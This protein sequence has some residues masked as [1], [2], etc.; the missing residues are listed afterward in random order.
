MPKL[1]RGV[2]TVV[3]ADVA[4]QDTVTGPRALQELAERAASWSPNFDYP[5]SDTLQELA[6]NMTF[7]RPVWQFE[8]AAKPLRMTTVETRIGGN[9]EKVRV[10]YLLYRLW[11]SPWEL[12]TGISH[13]HHS[14]CLLAIIPS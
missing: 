8:F 1:A 7:R 6:K 11:L 3:P 14:F 13:L 4:E 10:W 5:K 9:T 2:L 12:G